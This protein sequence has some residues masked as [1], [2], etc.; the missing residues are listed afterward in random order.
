MSP[1]RNCRAR[2]AWSLAAASVGLATVATLTTVVPAS[3]SS[4]DIVSSPSA[5][6]TVRRAPN[7]YVLGNAPGGGG[8]TFDSE[9]S[10]S[11]WSY[12][13]LYGEHGGCSWVQ[14]TH[15]SRTG[16]PGNHY[17]SSDGTFFR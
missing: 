7:S 15:L 10:Q 8:W 12:G 2:A 11:S 13:Y 6:V 1:R 4:R 5:W 3:A 14:D 17:C 9:T 16:T